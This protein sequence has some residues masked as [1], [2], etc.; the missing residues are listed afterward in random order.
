MKHEIEPFIKL[1]L[2][3]EPGTVARVEIADSHVKRMKGA[4]LI[5]GV[6]RCIAC[7]QDMKRTFESVQG[8]AH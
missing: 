8:P 7:L 4:E 6:N 3:D 5:E 1:Y 2:S